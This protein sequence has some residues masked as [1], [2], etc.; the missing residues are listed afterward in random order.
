MKTLGTGHFGS[1][2]L[3]KDKRCGIERVAKEIIKTLVNENILA[4][5][6]IELSLIKSLV[7][8]IQ[9]H[10]CIV[11]IFEIIE[12]NTRIYIIT[13]YLSGGVLFE[14]YVEGEQITEWLAARFM[15]DIVLSL[16]CLHK[17]KLV[18]RDIKPSNLIF[19]SDAPDSHIK[20]IDFCVSI[21]QK[22][23]SFFTDSVHYMAPEVING[24]TTT[25]SDIWSAGVLLY[26]MLSGVLPFNAENN[27]KTAA[28]ILSE[29][30][31][32]SFQAWETVSSEAKSL[33]QRMLHK[34][35]KER[36]T[37]EQIISDPWIQSYNRNTIKEVPFDKKVHE[38]LVIFNVKAI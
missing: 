8:Q 10:P 29:Q 12:T 31:D 38:S 17:F 28:V 24:V 4:K 16:N 7:I 21:L 3:I 18:H 5:L 1:V 23:Q 6:E 27:E 37:A 13:E 9:E 32:Y 22:K 33:V 20:L 15:S 14:R 34:N 25:K 2:Y 11:K 26:I 35:P 30:P 36:P 19:E